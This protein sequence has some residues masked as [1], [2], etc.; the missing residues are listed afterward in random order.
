MGG[1]RAAGDRRRPYFQRLR[2]ALLLRRGPFLLAANL[3]L[4]ASLGWMIFGLAPGALGRM[5]R[6]V[7]PLIVGAS[8]AVV[9]VAVLALFRYLFLVDLRERGRER[10]RERNAAVVANDIV[11]RLAQG[12]ASAHWDAYVAFM[13]GQI[14]ALYGDGA[15]AGRELDAV[16][17][18]AKPPAVQAWA[19]QVEAMVALLCSHR[20][21]EALARA[22][23]AQAL[24]PP[25]GYYFGDASVVLVAIAEALCGEG[26]PETEA[27]LRHWLRRQQDPVARVDTAFA[28]RVM[29]HQAGDRRRAELMRQTVTLEAPFC[30]PLHVD[31]DV[32]L[33]RAA[34][35][36]P[37]VPP[38]ESRIPDTV[39]PAPAA[40]A[41][42]A[43]SL[44]RHRRLHRL[45]IAL[46]WGVPAIGY[47]ILAMMTHR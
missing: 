42:Y 30:A 22:H 27:I 20:P 47:L 21:R 14:F 16:A 43:K 15:A 40:A 33:A 18:P 2:S 45:R 8:L 10:L 41:A 25:S 17:W 24:M 39:A 35:D 7:S 3:G 1:D 13:R 29:Y 31:P 11:A 9:A 23:R 46:E 44:Q 32:V 19:L 12:N 4:G 28:L 5:A 36:P 34:S 38:R 6:T 37:E 26:T